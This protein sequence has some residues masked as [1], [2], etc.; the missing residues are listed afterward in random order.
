MHSL[1]DPPTRQSRP[2]E[3]RSRPIRNGPT[4][5]PRAARLPCSISPVCRFVGRISER[6]PPMTD[7][8]QITPAA[9]P[10]LQVT[11]KQLDNFLT[12]AKIRAERAQADA[13][14]QAAIRIE[15]GV[16]QIAAGG[17]H[18]DD[19]GGDRLE[20]GAEVAGALEHEDLLPGRLD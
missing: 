15:R 12:S 2:S 18:D 4:F 8:W 17:E 6:H 20:L 9:N 14:T 3:S 5:G 19:L 10:P 13:G 11:S 16:G 1:H 7:A